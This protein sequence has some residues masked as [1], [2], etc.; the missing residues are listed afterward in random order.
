MAV[1]GAVSRPVRYECPRC[2]GLVSW[3]G[4]RARRDPNRR[5]LACT[6][7]ERAEAERQARAA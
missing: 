5:H 3:V 2:F 7:E 1:D 6:C 4:E